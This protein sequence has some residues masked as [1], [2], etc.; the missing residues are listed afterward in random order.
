MEIQ[1]IIDEYISENFTIQKT[2]GRNDNTEIN[3]KLFF[4][5]APVF[6]YFYFSLRFLNRKFIRRFLDNKG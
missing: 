5:S 1:R 2:G 3:L 4:L 6:L